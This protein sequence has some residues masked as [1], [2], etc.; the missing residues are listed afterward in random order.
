MEFFTPSPTTRAVATGAFILPPLT[1]PALTTPM[2]TP[3]LIGNIPIPPPLTPE[4]LA[5][6]PH[7]DA[8]A[9]LRTTIWTL[10][11]I[12]ALFLGAR[13]YCKFL[14]HR[15]LWWDDYILIGAWVSFFF[16]F[17][18]FLCPLSPFLPP[19]S[20]NANKMI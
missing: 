11:A 8:R 12:S 6:L 1:M 2:P 4:Q 9:Y 19:N 7:D 10:I 5:A 20:A 17:F 15:G 16:F 3:T 18:F 13:I 14:R